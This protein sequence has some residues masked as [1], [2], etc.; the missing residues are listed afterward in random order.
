MF[1]FLVGY[2]LGGSDR[3]RSTRPAPAP[4]HGPPAP[5][6]APWEGFTGRDWA[7]T[8][9][10]VVVYVAIAFLCLH[11]VFVVAP[12]IVEHATLNR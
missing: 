9:G 10:L 4:V 6:H 1:W 3:D 11:V 7:R 12:R 2:L 8:L 5:W